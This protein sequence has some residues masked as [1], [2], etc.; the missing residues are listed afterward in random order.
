MFR[1]ASCLAVLVGAPAPLH[2]PVAEG[3]VVAH[4]RFQEGTNGAP[5]S[6]ADSIVDSSGNNRHGTPV[7][8]PVYRWVQLPNS[9]L[10]LEFDGNDDRVFIPDHPV[11]QLTNSLTL[12]ADVRIN[13]YPTNAA[14]IGMFGITL[15][16]S[17]RR[18]GHTKFFVAWDETFRMLWASHG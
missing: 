8:N 16:Q 15:P 9:T 5:A 4:W 1:F 6:G 18:P 13:S 17:I 14:N 2:N 3:S 7:G 11:F 12:E 10:G